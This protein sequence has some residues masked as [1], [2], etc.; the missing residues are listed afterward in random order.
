M[1][2][3]ELLLGVDSPRSSATEQNQNKEGERMTIWSGWGSVLV[4]AASLVAYRLL[5]E[6]LSEEAP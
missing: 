1:H 5:V 2:V 4:I 6:K 3:P